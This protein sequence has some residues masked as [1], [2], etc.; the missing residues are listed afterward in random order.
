MKKIIITLGFLSLTPITFAQVLDTKSTS[1]PQ[2]ITLNQDNWSGMIDKNNSSKKTI[3]N[4]SNPELIEK[5]NEQIKIAVKP[6]PTSERKVS[7]TPLE[8]ISS[9]ADNML[10]TIFRTI[11]F[12]FL[13]V[14]IPVI[15]RLFSKHN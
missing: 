11:P 1:T 2:N 13:I 14:T 9:S 4:Q 8:E 6:E 5:R 12:V 3:S 15:F 10:D 7:L